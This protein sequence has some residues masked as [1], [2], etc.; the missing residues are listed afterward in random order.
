L[1]CLDIPS[2]FHFLE[3]RLLAHFALPGGFEI[4]FPLAL[5]EVQS[6][7]V[8]EG[9]HRK[10]G[11]CVTALKTALS[12]RV[13]GCVRVYYAAVCEPFSPRSLRERLLLHPGHIIPRSSDFLLHLFLSAV[14]KHLL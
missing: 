2:R 8:L 4:A 11:S 5:E 9:V 1:L 6:Q 12:G 3:R 14:Q 13:Q 7:L 10:I